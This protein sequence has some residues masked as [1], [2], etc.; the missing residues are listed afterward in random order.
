MK[1]FCIFF[2][3]R[4]NNEYLNSEGLI[5]SDIHR[6]KGQLKITWNR[7]RK[8]KVAMIGLVFICVFIILALITPLFEVLNPEAIES[9]RMV[10][11]K[12]IFPPYK[13]SFDNFFG[14]DQIGRDIFSRVLY[15]IRVSLFVGVLVRGL[16]MFV[17][18]TLGIISGYF[19]GI[20][21]VILMRLTD[22]LLAF[23][24]LLLAMAI[25]FVLG[26]SLSTVCIAL[27]IV[28]WPDVARLIRGQV[29]ALK[30]KEYVEASKALGASSVRIMFKEILPNCLALIVVSFSMGIPG[31][32]MYEAGLSF[33]G[34]GI[35]PPTP[36]LG[37]IIADGRGYISIAPW[38]IIFPGLALILIVIS[39]NMLGD[40]LIDALDPYA[41]D[42]KVKVT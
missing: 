40:G 10:D 4:K 30:T 3:R 22:V 8:D 35:Q 25:T 28:G 27:I 15:G 12:N 2:E 20:V 17:G 16:T 14:T 29:I 42:K 21:D 33:F 31:A 11:G 7:L 26:P 37:S 18:V 24:V 9:R 13:P 36:S 39:F 41:K 32:I 1:K 23:P 6:H 19:G 34:F 5:N 38:Y